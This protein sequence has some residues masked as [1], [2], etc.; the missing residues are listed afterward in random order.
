MQTDR[1]QH[2]Q[3]DKMDAEAT[4][5]MDGCS[6]IPSCRRAGPDPQTTLAMTQVRAEHRLAADIACPAP[7]HGSGDAHGGH[8]DGRGARTPHPPPG[9]CDCTPATSGLP[10]EWDGAW[11]G[12]RPAAGIRSHL[13]CR[14]TG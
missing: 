2:G 9:G 6:F 14:S 7:D 12:A 5:A 3:L 13:P 8:G 1:Q 10:R 4:D 11:A